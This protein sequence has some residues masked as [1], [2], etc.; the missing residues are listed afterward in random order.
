MGGNAGRVIHALMLAIT[1]NSSSLMQADRALAALSHK[2]GFVAAY[3]TAIAPNAR[4]FDGGSP[5]A[6]G[7]RAVLALL[8]A[9]QKDLRIDW[10]PQEATVAKSGDLGYTWGEFVATWQEKGTLKTSRGR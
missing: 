3:S 2:V 7:R 5:T 10:V 4:K 1:A 9:Y 6:K 8:H